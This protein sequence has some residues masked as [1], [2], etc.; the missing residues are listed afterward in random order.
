MR[1]LLLIL[2]FAVILVI[3]ALATG[4]LNVRAF[5]GGEPPEIT[6]GKNG[7]SAKAGQPP[8]FEVETGSV[9]VGSKEATVKV[10]TI[11]VQKAGQKSAPAPATNNA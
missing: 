4:F 6:A 7:I 5:G 8:S 10:P 9:K 1:A 3:A 2:V 11:E